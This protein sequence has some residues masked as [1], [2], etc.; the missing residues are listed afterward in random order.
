[1]VI[2]LRLDSSPTALEAT[3]V[4][5]AFV[6]NTL[7]L[8]YNNNV[9]NT[10][11]VGDFLESLILKISFIKKKEQKLEDLIFYFHFIYAKM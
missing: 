8:P 6:A 5:I 11:S 9:I 1:M 7:T 10:G 2:I 3:T 4:Y